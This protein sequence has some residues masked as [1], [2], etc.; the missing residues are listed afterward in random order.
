M[1][2][3][4]ARSRQRRDARPYPWGDAVPDETLC[5]FN[6]NEKGTTPVGKYSPKGDSPYGCA[7]MAGNVWEWTRSKW[8]DYPYR[9]DDGRDHW[10]AK[11]FAWCVAGRGA[12][13]ATSCAPRFASGT[14]TSSTATSVFGWV[15]FPPLFRSSAL[16]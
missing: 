9:S 5:N 10:R 4:C 15:A 12:T 3:G 13:P 11:G 2:E 8:V 16:C 7:D 14:T 6:N 1:G